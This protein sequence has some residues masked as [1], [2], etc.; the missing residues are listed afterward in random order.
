MPCAER[1]ARGS[2]SHAGHSARSAAT[3]REMASSRLSPSPPPARRPPTAGAC[4]T[5]AGSAPRACAR[6][7]SSSRRSAALGMCADTRARRLRISV[8]M[9]G[10]GMHSCT[11]S[12]S[13]AAAAS[14]AARTTRAARSARTASSHL[15][16]LVHC[17]SS[18]STR[19]SAHTPSAVFANGSAPALSSSSIASMP[20]SPWQHAKCS[21]VQPLASASDASAP[22]ASSARTMSGVPLFEPAPPSRLD[23]RMAA[24]C[25]GARP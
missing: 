1:S 16:R 10:S 13:S 25:S 24:A 23:A 8:D 9:V 18:A 4:T 22:R 11:D 6:S 3:P 2:T 14:T 15:S 21:G 17:S 19:P 20:R 5:R 7:A 12:P